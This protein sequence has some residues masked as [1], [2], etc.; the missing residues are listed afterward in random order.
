MTTGVRDQVT[1]A[2]LKAE[3]REIG[4]CQNGP[5]F[6]GEL[7]GNSL[8]VRELFGQMKEFPFLHSENLF[9]FALRPQIWVRLEIGITF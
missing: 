3:A 9:M 7:I 8:N 2:T 1:S 4:L 6:C 5:N